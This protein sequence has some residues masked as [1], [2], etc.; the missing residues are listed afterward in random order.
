MA[1]EQML[2]VVQAAG[3]LGISSCG[4]RRLIAKGLLRSVNVGARVLV[5]SSEVERIQ[6]EGVGQSRQRKQRKT[7][8]QK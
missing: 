7:D 5:P 8:Q 4:L 6:R 2:A 1:F 3:L